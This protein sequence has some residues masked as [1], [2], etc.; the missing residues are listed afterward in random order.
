MYGEN[1]WFRLIK[2]IIIATTAIVS[3]AISVCKITRFV[4]TSEREN[5]S[6]IEYA[7]SRNR[8]KSKKV[9]FHSRIWAF[10]VYGIVGIVKIV[11]KQSEL[12]P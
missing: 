11:V 8:S 4:N 5:S 7:Q 6:F 12:Y 9:G 2:L 10:M 3:W 1:Q